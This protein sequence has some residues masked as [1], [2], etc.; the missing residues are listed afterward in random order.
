M[1]ALDVA[2]PRGAEPLTYEGLRER[3]LPEVVF[4]GRTEHHSSQY[5]LHAAACLRGGLRPD[6]L[7]DAGLW[8]IPL[9]TYAVYAL[10]IYSRAAAELRDSTVDQVA[11]DLATRHN[12]DAE[13]TR[14]AP[15]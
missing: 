14:S 2:C 8:S 1:S 4:R 6:L 3:Y 15:R 13:P 5:A 9:R 10:V 12:L 11:R 7:N